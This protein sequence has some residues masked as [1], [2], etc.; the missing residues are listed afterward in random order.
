MRPQRRLPLVLS[1]CVLFAASA[2]ADD[3]KPGAGRY[4][5]GGSPG[6]FVRLDTV[7]GAASHCS[8]KGKIWRCEPLPVE[9]AAIK[10][11]LDALSGEVAKLSAVLAAL[12]A[13]V[14]ALGP[15]DQTKAPVVATTQ[16]PKEDKQPSFANQVMVRFFDLVRT[17]K[18]GRERDT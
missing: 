6:G 2:A 15:I 8:Q 9:D 14:A 16:D 4:L 5:L 7:T 13:R 11:R 12:N 18:H 10:T 3:A 1:V 17:L